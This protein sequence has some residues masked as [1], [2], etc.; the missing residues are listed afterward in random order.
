MKVHD[1]IK[2]DYG[3]AT[4]I[5][6]DTNPKNKPIVAELDTP[7]KSIRGEEH[8]IAYFHYSQVEKA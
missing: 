5:K 3:M 2:T 7:N 4:I 1:R 6:I 8:K